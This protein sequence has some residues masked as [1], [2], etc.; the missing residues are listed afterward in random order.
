MKEKYMNRLVESVPNVS[1]G[2]REQV[3]HTLTTTLEQIPGVVLLDRHVDADHN[4]SVF[5]LVGNPDAMHHALYGLIRQAKGLIDVRRHTGQHPRIGAVDVVPW[6]PFKN[7]TMEA[8]VEESRKL[9]E[10]VGRELDIPVFLYEQSCMHPERMRLETIRRGGIP[11]LEMRMRHDP[12]GAPDFGPAR[13]HSTAGALIMGARYFLIAFNVMLDSQD[14]RAAQTIAKSIRTSNGGLP[15]LKAIGLSLPSRGCVQISMNLTD[16]RITS[17]RSAFGAVEHEA[18]RHHIRIQESELIGLIPRDAWDEKLPED[19]K[20]T[21]WHS[22]C[23]LETAYAEKKL[24]Q[25]SS[26]RYNRPERR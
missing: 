23:V 10:R 8:C 4:R 26:V 5:T 19:L 15:A 22:H 14:I 20:I 25:C 1:E 18:A 17:I 16:F 13:V 6:I 24:F 12:T 7:V 3:I 11:A 9:G 2:R 21:N